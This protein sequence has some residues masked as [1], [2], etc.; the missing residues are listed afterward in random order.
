MDYRNTLVTIAPDCP[1]AV[2]TIPVPK[3]GK[4]TVALLEYEL[5]ST[6]PYHYTRVSLLFAVHV[7]KNGLSQ[8]ILHAMVMRFALACLPSPVP[9]CVLHPCQK[10]MAG[11]CI[12]MRTANWHL[13][14]AAVM[15]IAHLHL[16][17]RLTLRSFL[18]CAM[19]GQYKYA[20]S[21]R[22]S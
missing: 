11:G 9:A 19:R 20:F 7:K 1:V 15:R 22:R 21:R 5:L 13:W 6:H 4:P 16:A 8:R 3:A 18:P 12:T 2:A 17:I 14:P 10:P